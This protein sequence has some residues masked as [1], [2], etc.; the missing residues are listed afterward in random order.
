MLRVTIATVLLIQTM[1][2]LTAE[3][4][5]FEE[6]SLEL[7][8]AER[9]MCFDRFAKAY[10]AEAIITNQE[11]QAQRNDPG[12]LEQQQDTTPSGPIDNALFSI[13]KLRTDDPNFF[14]ISRSNN[15]G[16][17]EHFEFDISLKYPLLEWKDDYM[18]LFIYNGGYDFQKLTDEKIYDSSP[19][20][21]TKQNPGFA[22]EWDAEN[23]NEKYRFGI[24]HHSNGQTF[25]DYREDEE[26]D[27]E[28]E[29][30]ALWDTVLTVDDFN[31][32]RKD[33]GETPAVER[34]SR[35]SWYA[36]FRYQRMKNSAGIIGSDWWQYQFEIR[37]WYF[38]N[39]D[40]V[41]WET[42]EGEKPQIEKFDGIRA[43]GEIMLEAD[44][45]PIVGPFIPVQ[46]LLFRGELQTGLWAPKNVSGEFSLGINI[47]NLLITGY[48]YSGFTKDIAFYH[49]RTNHAGIGIE[50]R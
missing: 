17:I 23:E 5:V 46:N 18:V 44:K 24:F 7:N 1:P 27:S 47:N 36:Q 21:S 29:K 16:A 41:F 22:I 39:D 49:K 26:E 38:L 48:I 37:P 45:I 19:V 28:E 30:K 13:S 10:K 11:I 34:V 32:I 9:L 8:D 15:S 43:M 42:I 6:C 20:I 4:N 33:W 3:T 31:Q 2:A 40:K 14:G 25:N 35:S 50:L 12:A